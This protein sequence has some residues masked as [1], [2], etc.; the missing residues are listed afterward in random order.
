MK[1]S[2]LLVA[3]MLAQV[4]QT[5]VAK[6]HVKSF[7]KPEQV[8]SKYFIVQNIATEKLRVYEKCTETPNCPHRMVF[9]TNIVVGKIDGTKELWTRVGTFKIARWVKYY[10][11][12][13]G[14]YPSWYDPSFPATPGPGN[15]FTA[16]TSHSAMPTSV[17]TMRGAFGWYTALVYPNNNNQW[18]HGTI[19]WGADGDKFINQTRGFF[20][21]LFADPRS[22]GCT[23]LE[24]K[25]IAYL[26][27]FILPGTDVYRVYAMEAFADA[28]LTRYSAQKTPVLFDFIL[29][30]DQVRMSSPNSSAASAVKKRLS[31]NAISSSDILEE[32]SYQ[33]S[34]YPTGQPLASKRASS[35][36]SGDTYSLGHQAFKGVFLV[37]EGR[38]VNYDHPI[39][40]PRGGVEGSSAVLASYAVADVPYT[41][42]TSSRSS[43]PWSHSSSSSSTSDSSSSTSSDNL[44]SQGGNGLTSGH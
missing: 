32:G 24:N 12:G 33:A 7:V 11:D 37:D 6:S 44:S 35:G 16:W 20:A 36:L 39:E 15:S 18:I 3:A 30:K 27:S 4:G 19:G 9:E 22:H 31:S 42:V 13:A 43:T 14:L 34:Q 40:M 10:Q 38:F 25:A 23:R 29:T 1:K 5:A 2:I 17:G 28:N 21:N 26:Q 8:Q 41:L